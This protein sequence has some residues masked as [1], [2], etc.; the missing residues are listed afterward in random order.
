MNDFFKWVLKVTA[1]GILWVF[2]LSVRWDGK[3]LFSFA[4][5]T[6]V[7]NSLVQAAD[8]EFADLWYRLGRT[9]SATFSKSTPEEQRGM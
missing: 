7:Q 4:H 8:Q 5:E 9:A 2:I 1:I 6:L 3:M